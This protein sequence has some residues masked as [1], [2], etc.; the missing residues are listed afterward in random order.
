[1]LSNCGVEG[2][3]ESLGLQGDQTSPSYGDQSWIFI[4]RTD[5][6][7]E[8]PILWPPDVKNWPIGKYPDAGKDWRQRRG[9]QRVRWL[10]GV[11]YSMDMSLS[12]LQETV[13]GREAWSTEVHGVWKSQI[14]NSMNC[15]VHG[16]I[17]SQTRL[18][19]FH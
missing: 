1:M 12:K 18:S 13:K 8:V 5:A 11:T 6:E 16:V 3:W 14:W 7:A 17:K 15:M 10:D 4:G 9:W 2:S 19:N